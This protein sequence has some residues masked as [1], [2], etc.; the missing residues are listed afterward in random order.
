MP[1]Q[2][3]QTMTHI[4]YQLK[5]IP[6]NSLIVFVGFGNNVRFSLNEH[7]TELKINVKV[8]SVHTKGT[9]EII[10]LFPNHYTIMPYLHSTHFKEKVVHFSTVNK[11]KNE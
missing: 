3:I 11:H 4:V 10:G 8:P 1:C 7:F 2:V 6:R 5:Q 9:T